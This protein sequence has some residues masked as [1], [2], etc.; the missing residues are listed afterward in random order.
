MFNDKK[1]EE[2]LE[3]VR[4]DGRNLG[5]LD[6]VYRDDLEIV[7]TAVLG[8]DFGGIAV[9]QY[10]SEELQNN[11][12]LL[13]L[14]KLAVE[15]QK[16]R[17][18]IQ[19]FDIPIE[20]M[21]KQLDIIEEK[22]LSVI[23][24]YFKVK[25]SYLQFIRFPESLKKLIDR[26]VLGTVHNYPNEGILD[27][28]AFGAYHFLGDFLGVSS[29]SNHDMGS[30]QLYDYISRESNFFGISLRNEIKDY[31]KKNSSYS[32]LGVYGKSH[33]V[34][35]VS[36]PP[37]ILFAIDLLQVCLKNHSSSHSNDKIL[38]FLKSFDLYVSARKAG[39]DQKTIYSAKDDVCKAFRSISPDDIS[40][41][42][43]DYFDSLKLQD[44]FYNDSLDIHTI[45][46]TA[47]G[48]LSN[49]N[50][51]SLQDSFHGTLLDG[52][53]DISSD[54][55]YRSPF[56]KQEDA[57]GSFAFDDW[58]FISV[59]ADGVG[60][61]VGGDKASKYFVDRLLSWYQSI[62]KY[63]L[64]DLASLIHLLESE[65]RKI[66]LELIDM[67]HG[68]AQTTMVVSIVAGEYTIFANVGDSTAYTYDEETDQLIELSTQDSV[69]FGLSYEQA[70]HN[71]RNN[72]ITSSIGSSYDSIHI[73]VI[74]TDGQRILLSSDGVTDLISEE[75][76]KEC[77][78][79]HIQSQDIVRKAKFF[80]DVDSNMKRSDNISAIVIDLPAYQKDL[81]GRR[82]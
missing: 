45:T 28:L 67:Y 66:N 46:D 17:I 74:E 79:N 4:Q 14:C 60:G 38:D 36:L 12:S 64:D 54:K 40:K 49:S 51:V 25:D 34:T 61:Y 70:R 82:F 9:L 6:P 68:K 22:K 11:P 5:K 27:N 20:R 37:S 52:R 43:H 59:I 72:V 56:K 8:R 62:P 26:G 23:Q 58:H 30:S 2:A 47:R 7:A 21:R 15:F 57:V 65:V 63:L 80:P 81:H 1:R 39:I 78:R 76:L 35:T 19:S 33:D 75:N 42:F 73:H 31:Y 24:K 50:G 55:G 48:V 44:V 53:I 3:L 41:L 18:R 77:F 29:I 10:A 16:K 71:P 69:S 32:V 13:E